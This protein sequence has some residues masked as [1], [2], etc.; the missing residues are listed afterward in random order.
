MRSVALTQGT[1]RLFDN[2]ITTNIDLN[3]HL[4][5]ITNNGLYSN[6]L[7]GTIQLDT[8]YDA[9]WAINKSINELRDTNEGMAIVSKEYCPRSNNI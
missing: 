2:V 3:T 8:V 5:E 1:L 7:T 4:L 9:F 6:H